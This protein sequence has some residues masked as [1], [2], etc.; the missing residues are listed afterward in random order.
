MFISHNL[1]FIFIHVHR[2]GGTSITNLL[3]GQLGNKLE[4]ISQHGNAKTT[5]SYLLE[6]HPEYFS[7][8]F[9]RNPYERILSWYSLINKNN[10]KSLKEEK[11]RFE[12]F[13]ELN[14]ASDFTNKMFHYNQLDYFTN[15]KGVLKVHKIFRYENFENQIRELFDYLELPLK[16]IP[17]INNTSSKKYK[18]YYT[19]KSRDLITQKCKKD[20][21]YFNYTF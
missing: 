5:E 18:D 2:T 9:V 19:Q 8:G 14:L 16:D 7:C 1:K 21:E 3:R 17:K 11:I 15:E 20:I 10:V 12:N 6:K 4:E 13:I